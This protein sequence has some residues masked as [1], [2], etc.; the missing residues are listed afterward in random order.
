MS[1]RGSSICAASA[2]NKHSGYLWFNTS[3][4]LV[5]INGSDYEWNVKMDVSDDTVID[6]GVRI[7]PFTNARTN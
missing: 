3:D 1:E 5:A 7:D 4:D 2:L 6:D